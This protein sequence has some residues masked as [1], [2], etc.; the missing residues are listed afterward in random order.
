[1][2]RRNAEPTSLH[3]AAEK[4]AGSLTREAVAWLLA[5]GID[6]E[7]AHGR[8]LGVATS[9]EPGHEQFRNRLTI[10]YLTRSGVVS[11]KA[12]ALQEGVKPKYTGLSEAPVHLYNV[13]ALHREEPYVAICEGELDALVMDAVAGVPAVGVAGVNNWK[14][15]FYRVFAG[16]SRVFVVTDND[17]TENGSNPGHELQERIVRDLKDAA[18]V[19]PPPPG[20]DLGEWVLRDGPEAVRGALGL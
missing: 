12:R 7:T 10:P 20:L 9:P 18:V 14:P 6:E 15:H 19:V 17:V 11:I 2:A 1:M 8:L 13:N 5:R 4:Y 16:Y 3:L